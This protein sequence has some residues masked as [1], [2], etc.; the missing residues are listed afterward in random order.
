MVDQQQEKTPDSESDPDRSDTSSMDN[1]FT[2]SG[3]NHFGSI[4]SDIGNLHSYDNPTAHPGS[5]QP[6]S[7]FI[8][9][10]DLIR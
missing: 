7:L 9:F 6:V 5:S 4:F 2:F 8:Y 10:W 1:L 3:H